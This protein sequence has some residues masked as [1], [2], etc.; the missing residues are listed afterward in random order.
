MLIYNFILNKLLWKPKAIK[1]IC[2]YIYPTQLT[3]YFSNITAKD[4]YFF[5]SLS[6]I[7]LQ[8]LK[9]VLNFK[10]MYLL[11]NSKKI[12]NNNLNFFFK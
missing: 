9:F 7:P 6:M 2:W 1:C 8:T 11:G 10:K 3:I 12:I 5:K 4:Y